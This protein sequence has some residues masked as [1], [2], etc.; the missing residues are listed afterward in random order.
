MNKE[1]PDYHPAYHRRANMAKLMTISA[2]AMKHRVM[3][4]IDGQALKSLSLSDWQGARR[5]AAF[6]LK[7]ALLGVFQALPGETR[8]EVYQRLYDEAKCCGAHLGPP[9]PVE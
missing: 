1:K 7:F 6:E 3:V 9:E 8:A 5:R 4:G 2:M